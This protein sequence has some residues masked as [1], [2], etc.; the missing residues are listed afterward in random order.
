MENQHL[1]VPKCHAT[2]AEKCDL[3]N[4]EIKQFQQYVDNSYVSQLALLLHEGITNYT[5]MLGA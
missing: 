5:H 4:D 1:Q 2:S 3:T